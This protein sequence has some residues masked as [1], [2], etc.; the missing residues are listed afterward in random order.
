[1][2]GQRLQTDPGT[3]EK[4]LKESQYSFGNAKKGGRNF[5]PTNS[6]QG[7]SPAAAGSGV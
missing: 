1:M 7:P 6:S 5:F 2:G 3:V 4:N